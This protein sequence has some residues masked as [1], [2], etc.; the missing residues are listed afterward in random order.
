MIG[1]LS[2]ALKD[3]INTPGT[4][5]DPAHDFAKWNLMHAGLSLRRATSIFILGYSLPPADGWMWARLV[6]LPN[7]KAIPVYVASRG[8]SADIVTKLR[9]AGFVKAAMLD[10]GDIC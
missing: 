10:N 7:K 9:D 6:G 1:Y 8:H 2:D 3:E 4:V 5:A